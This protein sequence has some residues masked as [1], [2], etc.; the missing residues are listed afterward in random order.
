MRYLNYQMNAMFASR[1]LESVIGQLDKVVANITNNEWVQRIK[2][3]F[4]QWNVDIWVR[5]IEN[6]RSRAGA[7]VVLPASCTKH[8]F[9]TFWHDSKHDIVRY[10]CKGY[11][12]TGIST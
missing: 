5:I 11:V 3:F 10:E 12:V 1:L 2:I 7:W 9:L 6:V 8:D 4:L